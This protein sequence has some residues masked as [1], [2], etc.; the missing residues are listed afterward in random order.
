M[1]R[2]GGGEGKWRMEEG[3]VGGGDIRGRQR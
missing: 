2:E 1:K 3:E